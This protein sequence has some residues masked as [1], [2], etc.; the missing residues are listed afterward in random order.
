MRA[1]DDPILCKS[2]N[3]DYAKRQVKLCQYCAN[4]SPSIKNTYNT[5]QY[6][7]WNSDCSKWQIAG[8]TCNVNTILAV[9]SKSVLHSA[10]GECYVS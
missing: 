2:H 8:S 5:A 7:K 9:T 10:Q 4:W 6:L 1:L 3:Q